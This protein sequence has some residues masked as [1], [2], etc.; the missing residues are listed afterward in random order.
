MARMRGIDAAHAALLAEDPECELTKTALRRLV[1]SGE[2]P[3]VR[4]GSKYLVDLDR[5]EDYLTNPPAPAEEFVEP[6]TIR[7]IAV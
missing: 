5:L 3:S 4:V 6:G 7:R 2:V 1:V